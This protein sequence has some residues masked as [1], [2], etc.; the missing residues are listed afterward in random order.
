MVMYN[1]M[2]FS[3]AGLNTPNQTGLKSD[4]ISG[5]IISQTKLCDLSSDEMYF[6]KELSGRLGGETTWSVVMM[7]NLWHISYCKS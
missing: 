3:Q 4:P 7:T 1:R 2:H 5:N 6:K